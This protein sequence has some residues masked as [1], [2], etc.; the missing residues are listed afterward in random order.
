MTTSSKEAATKK[1]A[2]RAAKKTTK[3]SEPVKKSITKAKTTKQTIAK[4]AKTFKEDVAH[5][6]SKKSF[7]SVKDDME[8]TKKTS[9]WGLLRTLAVFLVSALVLAGAGFGV[10]YLHHQKAEEVVLEYFEGNDYRRGEQ[11]Q[12]TLEEQAIEPEVVLTHYDVRRPVYSLIYTNPNTPGQQL[13]EVTY[14]KYEGLL[15]Y[16]VMKSF[17]VIVTGDYEEAKELATDYDLHL[18]SPDEEM[19]EIIPL[20]DL[21]LPQSQRD[22]AQQQLEVQAEN[23]RRA[24]EFEQADTAGRIEILTNLKAEAL[25]LKEAVES[26]ASE[27]EGEPIPAGFDTSQIDTYVD[28]LDANIEDLQSQEN[29]SSAEAVEE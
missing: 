4:R 9:S 19:V 3:A 15:D 25:A 26:G 24:L 1:T 28:Q 16:E 7:Q 6:K 12:A 2:K 10:V 11:L 5:S 13:V 21:D 22:Q 14:L 23:Q 17:R 20:Q 8:Q 29:T 18:N 27:F